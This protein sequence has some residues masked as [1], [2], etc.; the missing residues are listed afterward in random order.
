V[1]CFFL[2]FLAF[3]QSSLLWSTSFVLCV[4]LPIRPSLVVLSPPRTGSFPVCFRYHQPV[5]CQNYFPPSKCPGTPFFRHTFGCFF[6]LFP[7][8]SPLNCLSRLLS[9]RP[10]QSTLPILPSRALDLSLYPRS[11]ISPNFDPFFFGTCRLFF[12][13]FCS[14]VLWVFPF[15]SVPFFSPNRVTSWLP[16]VASAWVVLS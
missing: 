7:S 2:F 4:F 11:R 8:E 1:V 15:N 14:L 3:F 12:P 10:A 5:C 9:G 13:R 6:F 16:V